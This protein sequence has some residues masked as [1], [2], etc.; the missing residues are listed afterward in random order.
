MIMDKQQLD[1]WSPMYC[2]SQPKNEIKGQQPQTAAELLY[3]SVQNHLCR[4]VLW[5]A[6]R[7]KVSKVDH[8]EPCGRKHKYVNSPI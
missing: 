2:L 8:S 5:A 6:S 4:A 1:L 3:T 7:L